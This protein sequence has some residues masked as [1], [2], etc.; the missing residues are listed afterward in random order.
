MRS[1]ILGC[2]GDDFSGLW[3]LMGDWDV[4][5]WKGEICVGRRDE[6]RAPFLGARWGGGRLGQAGY[7]FSGGGGG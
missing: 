2:S 3:E 5:A 7:F 4:V 6:K 1:V